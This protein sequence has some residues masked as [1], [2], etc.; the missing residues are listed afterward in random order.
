VALLDIITSK[1][2]AQA[3]TAMTHV[4]ITKSGKLCHPWPSSIAKESIP[5]K[6]TVR[7]FQ[8]LPVRFLNMP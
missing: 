4:E 3:D 1:F 6:R 2:N 5:L 8:N 7:K